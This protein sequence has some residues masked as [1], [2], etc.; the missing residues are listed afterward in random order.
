MASRN[1]TAR[2]KFK[3]GNTASVGNPG[4]HRPDFLTQALISQLHEL[5][6]KDRRNRP[7]F[8]RIVDKMI[9]AANEGDMRAAAEIF[10]RVQGRAKAVTELKNPDGETLRVEYIKRI[11][12]DPLIVDDEKK[13]GS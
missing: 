11:I 2:G 1:Q 10:D 5:D 9:A 8:A 13:G 7:R 6:K 3:P 4:P 12:V